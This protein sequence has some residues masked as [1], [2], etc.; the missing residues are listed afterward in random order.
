MEQNA[1]PGFARQNRSSVSAEHHLPELFFRMILARA[2]IRGHTTEFQGDL[3]ALAEYKGHTILLRYARQYGELALFLDS[4][5]PPE[6]VHGLVGKINGI[7]GAEH[8]FAFITQSGEPHETTN[9]KGM[10]LA[11]YWDVISHSGQGD[12]YG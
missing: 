9:I 8:M 10:Q 7:L 12:T 5:L 6:K 1:M 11:R 2:R 4:S 3:T